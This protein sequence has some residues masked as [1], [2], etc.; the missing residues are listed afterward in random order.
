[1]P[2]TIRLL[3][4]VILLAGGCIEAPPAPQYPDITFTDKPKIQM[5]VGKVEVVDKYL[6]PGRRP[7][8]EHEFPVRPAAMLARWVSDRLQATGGPAVVRVIINDAAATETNLDTT[9]GIKGLFKDQRAQRYDVGL[10]VRVEVEEGGFTRAHADAQAK[11]SRTVA[12]SITLSDREQV[13]YEIT[14]ALGQDIDAELEMNIRQ[15]LAA[16]LR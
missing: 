4:A 11:R 5:A 3:V 15:F 13:Y 6:P 9:K 7:N 8:V 10:D 12:E 16:Y 2:H 1:M 14:K